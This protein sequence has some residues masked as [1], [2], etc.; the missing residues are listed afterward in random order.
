MNS[1]FI[2]I[3]SSD[4]NLLRKKS[5]KQKIKKQWPKVMII[6]KLFILCIYSKMLIAFH[7]HCQC[8][9]FLKFRCQCLKHPFY[10][11][12]ACHNENM[13]MQ[14]TAIFHGSKNEKF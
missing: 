4:T 9:F 14:Y 3:S 11:S 7:I 2:F 6:V 5:V 8:H 1:I 13:S 10:C 12:F